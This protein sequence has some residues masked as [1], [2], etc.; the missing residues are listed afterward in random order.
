M[1]LYDT[2]GQGYARTRASDH[3]ITDRLVGLLNLPSNATILDVGAGTGKYARAFADRG[4]SVIALEPS[5]VMQAQSEPHSGVS[6][7]RATAES[8]PLPDDSVDGAIV[9]LAVHH[10]E[11]RPT[12]P[13]CNLEAV[14]RGIHA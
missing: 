11:G 2:I 13:V 12:K 1:T 3:R 8:I 6:F 7:I 10:F 4:Y 14:G 5:E 9:V